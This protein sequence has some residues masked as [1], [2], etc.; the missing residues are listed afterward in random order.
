[1]T[2]NQ[3]DKIVKLARQQYELV[4]CIFPED[5]R[6]MIEYL[7]ESEHPEEI[8][9]LDIAIFAHN[10]YNNDNIDRDEFFDWHGL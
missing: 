8:R 4:G 2:R 9:C 1:M 5:D 10:I 6:E 7:W 3:R